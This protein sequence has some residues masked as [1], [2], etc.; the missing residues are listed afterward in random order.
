MI[1]TI[2]KLLMPA[3]PK[4]LPEGYRRIKTMVCMKCKT[5][6]KVRSEHSDHDV[7]FPQ[8]TW[9][10]Q[11]EGQDKIAMIKLAQ[12]VKELTGKK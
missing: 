9:F 3:P 4:P 11:H 8:V 12:R 6:I 1:A 7:V 5:E 2:R 10:F